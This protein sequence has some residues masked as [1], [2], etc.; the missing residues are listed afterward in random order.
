[1][2]LA[3]PALLRNR[4]FDLYWSGVVL[5][6]IGNRGTLAVN[7]F[8]VYSLTGSTALVGII[9]LVHGLSVALLSPL[10]GALADRVDRRRLLQVTQGLSLLA[11][12]AL[13]VL[14][15]LG[16]LAV[17]HIY[18]AVLMNAA[19]STFDSPSRTAMIPSL[20]PRAHLP[21]AFALVNPS[22]ELATL[23]GPVLG[24][25]LMALGGPQLMYFVD[26]GS[27][28]VLV[29]ILPLLRVRPY[30]RTAR[31]MSILSSIREGLRFV[32][33]RRLIWQLMSLDLSASL[34][35]AW[36]VVLPALAVDYLGVGE[37]SYGLLVAAPSAGAL[38][39]T[40]VILKLVHSGQSGL[41]VLGS[42]AGFGVACIALAHS[43]TMALAIGA[44]LLI[45]AFDSMAAVVRHIVV[46]L[47]TPDAIRGR[48]TSIYQIASRGGPAL[49]DANIG[50]ISGLVGPVTALSLGGIVPILYSAAAFLWGRDI[51]HL[52]VDAKARREGA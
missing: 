5:S 20:V 36:R 48:V 28:A 22:R 46:H 42:T 9:G 27:Y 50:W 23:I 13:G 47:E 38:I 40:A 2:R 18:A 31:A 34:F 32:R 39:G 33:E 45:G 41:I 44:G 12:L 35:G 25:G 26:A 6:E 3:L 14:T 10:G 4:D 37:G 21:Q 11:S 29:L 8:H 16:V 43:R 7:L 17:W 51:R 49:G 19:A 1:M 15:M 30:E 24:G 52:D